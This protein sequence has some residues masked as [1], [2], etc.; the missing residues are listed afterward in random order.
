MAKKKTEE[1]ENCKFSQDTE[2]AEIILC[3]RFPPQGA[4]PGLFPVT[5]PGWWCGEYK[6]K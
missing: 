6:A 3:V 5:Q 1:C 4:R 2:D